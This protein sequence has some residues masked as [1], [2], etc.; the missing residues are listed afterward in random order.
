MK[1]LVC[2]SLGTSISKKAQVRP[3]VQ[4]GIIL[5][6]LRK[7]TLEFGVLRL[8]KFAR[9]AGNSPQWLSR[10]LPAAFGNFVTPPFTADSSIFFSPVFDSQYPRRDSLCKET[11]VNFEFALVWG[12]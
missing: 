3:L 1:E 7:F 2:Y 4:G 11:V 12:A 5:D 6:N 10:E 8:R 9:F